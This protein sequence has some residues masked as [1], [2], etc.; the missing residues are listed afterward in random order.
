MIKKITRRNLEKFLSKYSTNNEVLEHV[1]NPFEVEKEF[2]RVLKQGGILI[3]TT[4]FI[5]PIHDAPS[6][7]WRFTKYGLKM[8]FSKWEIIELKEET[9]TFSSLA[10]LCQRI[11]FQTNLRL[12]K[13]SK[14]AVF[15]SAL[16]LDKMNWII[17]KEFGD[18]KRK[19][20]EENILSSGYYI[21]CRK[22]HE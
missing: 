3:L 10:V 21:V 13:L 14:L 5:F 20:P 6:D 1:K 11:G 16:I 15:I 18:I 22:E 9:S 2:W 4:R 8:I 7:F 12:N 17:L 19:Y